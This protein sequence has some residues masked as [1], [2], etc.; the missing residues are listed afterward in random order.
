MSRH[1]V[2]TKNE[3]YRL[4][5]VTRDEDRWED[6]VLYMLTAVEETA[7]KGITAVGAI[8]TAFF[9]YKHRIR[10]NYTFYSEDLINNLFSHPYTRIQFVESELYSILT[11]RQC[12]RR[13]FPRPDH[14]DCKE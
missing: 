7:R 14:N 4:L 10:A 13:R 5:Q 1:I 3:N 9:D 12:S 2:R 6:W 11:A 8:R